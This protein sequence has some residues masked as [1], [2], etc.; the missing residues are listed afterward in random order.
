M[1]QLPHSFG[2]AVRQLRETRGWSQEA[3]AEK[4]DLNRSYVGEIE[5]GKAVASLLTLEKL[6]QALGL[7]ASSL[8][9]HC[10]QIGVAHT[11]LR[12]SCWL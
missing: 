3:L 4:A 1:N 11:T 9:A 12:A 10:E 8:L 5:R 6:A 7:R 2:I